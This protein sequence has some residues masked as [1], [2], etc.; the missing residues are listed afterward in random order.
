MCTYNGAKYLK[1]QLDSIAAQTRLPDELVVC[2]DGSEDGSRQIIKSFAQSAPFPVRL[3]INETN[4][5]STKNFE[6]AIGLC[7]REII[8]L[9]DQDDLW[10]PHK[11][12]R[13]C[14]SLEE[15][16]TA[17]YVFSDAELVDS[18]GMPTGQGLWGSLRMESALMR[19]FRATNQVA[20]LLRR[21]VVTGA[22]MAFRGS[23]KNALL[24]IS[25]HLVHDYWISSIASSIGAYGIPLS[26][27]L[28]QYR[29]HGDQQ[30]GAGGRSILEKV[31]SARQARPTLYTSTVQGFQDMRERLLWAAFEGRTGSSRHIG[32]V[33]EKIKHCSHRAEA[34]SAHGT[35]KVSKVISE[36]VTGGYRRYSDSWRS[37]VRDL[38]F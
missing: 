17:G 9:A 13:L 37:V 4:L 6:K 34:H 3:E 25:S 28:I 22:T 14:R 19:E 35:A 26:E 10:K 8:A 18:R 20:F 23:L 29:Q 16:P 7:Q 31:R 24:P 32:L 12:E 15:N 11:L 36:V 1:A 38:C 5:G 21:T 30:I 27:K 2:D 33:E